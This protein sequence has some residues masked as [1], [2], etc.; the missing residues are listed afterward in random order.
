[1]CLCAVGKKEKEQ[2][3]RSFSASSS[4]IFCGGFSSSDY[5]LA[6]FTLLLLSAHRSNSLGRLDAAKCDNDEVKMNP[7]QPQISC[8]MRV[9]AVGLRE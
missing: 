7:E 3:F 2:E 4:Q 6:C 9:R 1:M 8:R 5:H